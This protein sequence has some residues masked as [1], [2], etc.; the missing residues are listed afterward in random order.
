MNNN[1]L[2]II[3]IEVYLLAPNYAIL[4]KKYA[5]QIN[6]YVIS[7]QWSCVCVVILVSNGL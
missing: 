1:V 7:I 4:S 2:S 6:N 5:K 3:V